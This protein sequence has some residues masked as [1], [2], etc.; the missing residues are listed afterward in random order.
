MK[1]ISFIGV[2]VEGCNWILHPF[3]YH[4][5]LMEYRRDYDREVLNFR[6]EKE[7]MQMAID[8]A[9][10]QHKILEK[11]NA[12]MCDS[13]IEKEKIINTLNDKILDMEVAIES[14]VENMR[15]AHG[16]IG[17]MQKE[18]NKLKKKIQSLEIVIENARK[19]L[20]EANDLI[21]KQN[22]KIEVLSKKTARE[23]IDYTLMKMKKE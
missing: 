14:Y 11:K 7:I 21:V 22:N 8:E 17:G 20:V 19:K 4:K 18:I 13:I 15:K 10:K 9:V 12:K 16:K 2:L 23:K 1:R 3:A 5:E 6:R